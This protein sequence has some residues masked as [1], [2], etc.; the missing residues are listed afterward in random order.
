MGLVYAG[1][2]QRLAM[3]ATYH[4]FYYD[5][6][7]TISDANLVYFY[8]TAW[9]DLRHQ[10]RPYDDHAFL[11]RLLRSRHPL[12]RIYRVEVL[13]RH[14]YTPSPL[15]TEDLVCLPYHRSLP[16]SIIQSLYT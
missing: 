11:A 14:G 10:E 1:W 13:V 7:K 15:S 16:S 2:R 12:N 6:L 4:L 8:I 9:L 5:S 3:T